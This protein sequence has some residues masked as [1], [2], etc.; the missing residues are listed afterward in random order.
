MMQP[1]IYDLFWISF[2]NGTKGII[3]FDM[4]FCIDV[5]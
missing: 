3:V 4:L 1:N 5:R 2:E